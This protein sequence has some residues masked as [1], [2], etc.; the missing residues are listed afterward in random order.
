MIKRISLFLLVNLAV[1]LMLNLVIKILGIESYISAS[2]INYQSLMLFCL[3]WGMGGAFIS[4]L[5]SK[6]MAIWTMRLRLLDPNSFNHDEQRLVQTV[7][8]LAQSANLSKMPD[9]AIYDSPEVNA[10]ATGPSK[11]NSLVAVSTGLLSAM[12]SQEVEGVLGHEVSHIANGDMVTLTLLQG[13]L[14][15]FVLFFAKVL[16]WMAASAM[17]RNSDDDSSSPSW[18]LAFVIEMALQIVFGVLASIVVAW[19]SRYREYRA[20]AGGAMLAG[21]GAMIR[22]LQRL[23]SASQIVTNDP[24]AHELKNFKISGGMSGFLALFASHPP[25]EDRIRALQESV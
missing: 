24:R 25:L 5:I 22:A 11:D 6:R 1:M 13:V 3:V 16:A 21:K 7:H 23:Q 9:V 20:D 18:G 15:A 8:R 14:N 2:G 4:L 10:F 17:S 19:F 12:S